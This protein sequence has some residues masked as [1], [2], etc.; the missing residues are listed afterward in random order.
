[1]SYDEAS[2]PVPVPADVD[3]PDK[4]VAGLT[5]RQAA[6]LAAATAVLWLAWL[7]TRRFTPLP[8]F[9][10]AAA[11]FAVAAVVVTLGARDGLSADRWLAAG[12]RQARTPRRQVPAPE[13]IPP[14]PGWLAPAAAAQAR[15]LPAPLHLPADAISPTGALS[16]GSD[17]TAA[18]AAASV[19]NFALRTPA[20]QQ[21]LTA[22]FGR[23]LNSLQHPAQILVRAHRIDLSAMAAAVKTSA[24][25]LPH[26]ALEHAANGHAA[27]LARL[28][29]D[30]DLLARQVL[31]TVRA[32]GP[33]QA[34]RAITDGTR[35]LAAASVALTPLDGPQ[36]SAVLAACCR[37]GQPPP[38]PTAPPGQVITTARTEPEAST[39]PGA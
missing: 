5:A 39:W 29:E 7:T 19:V 2:G 37:P 15:P 26:P 14:L 12:L 32:P 17:G 35:A 31:I 18:I 3:Q 20:E 34:A 16:L 21:A 36:A 30:R 1:V 22:A 23:W 25:G 27:F 33:G 9:A 38:P 11:P 24:P 8:V 4:I 13:G 10:A 6:I 28:A